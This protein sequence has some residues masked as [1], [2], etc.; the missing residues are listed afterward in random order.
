MPWAAVIARMSSDRRVAT[1]LAFARA[2]E[3]T[4]LDDAL[5]L[6]DLIITDLLAQAKLAGEKQRLRTLRDL[7]AA[8]LQLRDVCA[9]LLDESCSSAR[10]RSLAFARVPRPQLAEAMAM[11]ESLARPPE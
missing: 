6:L 1:L 2:F 3:S 8:A 10:V 11:V 5:D 4:A 9:V 7:D